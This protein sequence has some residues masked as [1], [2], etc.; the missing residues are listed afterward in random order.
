MRQNILIECGFKK[1]TRLVAIASLAISFDVCS[2]PISA[3]QPGQQTFSSLVDAGRAIYAAAQSP[4][5]HAL[6]AVLGPAGNEIAS[7]G[8]PA[9][10]HEA[11][12][13]FASK[14]QEMHRFVTEPN[15]TVML[16]VGAENWPLPI[17]LIKKDGAWFFDTDAGKNEIL[18]RRIGK[19]ELTAIEACDE[20]VDAEKQYFT[21]APDGRA[22]EYAQKLVA[23]AGRHD[24]LYWAETGDQ[25]NSLLDPRIAS[26]SGKGPGEQTVD[27]VPFDGYFFRILKSQGPHAPGGEKDYVVSGKMTAGFAFV[28]YPAEYRSSGVMT[29]IVSKAGVVYEKDLG[30]NTTQ[31]GEAMIAFNPDSTWS[32]EK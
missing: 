25:G 3:Q 22:K 32:K 6:M 26:A 31:L 16:I 4:G 1:V 21:K 18:F 19:N 5:D 24:G 29:F 20:L 2:V 15:G 11:R 28:A 13:G 17:P 9:E 14:Y 12:T 7:S 10:D 27:P 30:P 8:D 23:D